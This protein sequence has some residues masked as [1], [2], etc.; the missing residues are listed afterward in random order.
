MRILLL[1][2]NTGEGHNS[3]SRAIMDVLE[4]RGISCDMRDSLAFLSPKFSKFICNWHARIYKYAPRLWD[5][6]YGMM[7]RSGGY[8]D[9]ATPIYELLSLGANK[10]WKMLREGDYDAVICVHPFSGIMMTEV[11]RLWHYSVP[12][13]FVATDYTCS[14]TVEQ[15][16]LDGYFIPHPEVAAEFIRAGLNASDLHSMGIPVRQIFYRSAE[17]TA[18][19]KQLELP[20][21]GKVVLLMCGSMG[22]GPI[23]RLVKTLADALPK[24]AC[25]VAVCGNNEK[26]YEA[27]SET[28]APNL[29]VLGY[30]KNISDYMDAAD[31]LVTKPGGLSTTEAA[32]KHL[33][34]VLI[35]AIGGCE[36]RNFDFFLSHG[37]A[38]GSSDVDDVVRQTVLL[39][40]NDAMREKMT[41]ALQAHFRRN[42]AQEIAD[43]VIAGAGAYRAGISAD[44]AGH[45]PLK[46]GGSCM[47]TTE[48]APKQTAYNLAR[49]FAG[50]SQ[51]RMRYTVYAEI[52]RKEGMEWIARIFEETAENEAVHAGKFL[53]HIRSL[54]ACTENMDIAAGYPY[55]VG[56]TQENLLAARNAEL[57]EH[58]ETYPCF[59]ELA[60]RE[61]YDD[62][63]RL[64]MQIARVEGVHH[65]TFR[66]IYEQLV[67]GTLT[68]HSEPTLWRCL[69]CGYTYEGIRACDPCPVCGKNVGWQEG[70]L[71]EKMLLPKK[72]SE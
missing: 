48:N 8:T 53:E 38:V 4:A 36:S 10:L 33:P 7:E 62:T 50:E 64:W 46:E 35:N 28:D 40:E 51:A 26:L 21:N 59:A 43:F 47:E 61:G 3:T 9:D 44:E 27:L 29:R 72:K 22:C 20:E 41:A 23:R 11:R 32:N 12:C 15:C 5:A 69:H 34:T 45:T 66:Q 19:R 57:T 67:S 2:A 49:S 56:T 1:S 60:R 16:R 30:T 17:K 58:D 39:T 70:T 6:S 13:Y 54:G 71:D 68:E 31:V 37:F 24:D 42:S 52:A 14:P 25:L 63:A 18:M 55:T 65:N